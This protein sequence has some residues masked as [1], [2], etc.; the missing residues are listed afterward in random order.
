MASIQCLNERLPIYHLS[1]D[2]MV[3]DLGHIRLLVQALV[4]VQFGNTGDCHGY[5]C[6]TDPVA[7]RP[8]V[9]TDPEKQQGAVQ[10]VR[11]RQ[12]RNLTRVD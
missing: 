3:C 2:V 5:S 7:L 6:E 8:L 4:I 1:R 12:V 10:M 11:M 9:Q